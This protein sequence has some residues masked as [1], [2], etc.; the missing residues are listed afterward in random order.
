VSIPVWER[1]NSRSWKNSWLEKRN[2][3]KNSCLRT[4]T[5]TDSKGFYENS[6]LG[7]EI[8]GETLGFI[9]ETYS[10]LERV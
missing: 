7:K 4:C 8:S 10:R 1:E 9:R 3:R 2:F 5:L 6:G